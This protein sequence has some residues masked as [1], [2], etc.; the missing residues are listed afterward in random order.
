LVYRFL[1][2]SGGVVAGSSGYTPAVE[3]EKNEA[4]E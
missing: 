4:T 1:D 3:G 2:R